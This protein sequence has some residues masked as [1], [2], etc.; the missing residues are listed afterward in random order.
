[1]IEVGFNDVLSARLANIHKVLGDKEK[2]YARNGNRL[3]NFDVAAR[4]GKTSPEEALKGMWMKH[5]VSVF[6]MIDSPD[7]VSHAMIDEKLGDL[8]NY[9]ILLE[10]MLVRGL[11]DG[12]GKGGNRDDHVEM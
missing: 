9:A 1:M 4:I 2:E 12:F 7:D 6:D 8:I 11:Q 3:H 10:W 5:I